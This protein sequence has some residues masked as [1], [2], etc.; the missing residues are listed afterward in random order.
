MAAVHHLDRLPAGRIGKAQPHVH[1]AHGVH[2]VVAEEGFGGAQPDKAHALFFRVLHLAQAA[3][4]VR[5]VAPVNT[6]YGRGT[7]ADGRAH[8][9]HRG[10]TTADHHHMLARRIQQ[11]AVEIGHV[12]AQALAVG[13][14]Q[15]IQ[16]RDDAGQAGA[17]AAD[18]ARLV[19]AGGQQ[20]RV[21]ARAQLRERHVT[22]HLGVQVEHDAA[23]LQQLPAAQH[24]VLFQL[25]AGD[26]VHHQAAHAV[27][28]VINMHLVAAAAQLLGR[29]KPARARAHHANALRELLAGGD[30][31]D[32]ALGERVVGDEAL[33]GTDGDALEAAL[34][35]AVAL[36]QPVLRADAAADLGEVVGGRAHL[37]GLVQ[38]AFRGQLQPVRNVVVQRAVDGTERHAALAAPAG[39]RL[40]QRDGEVAVDLV[41]I[42][43]ACR[44]IALV[45]LV[46][47]HRRELQHAVCHSQPP[48]TAAAAASEEALGK[49]VNRCE[50]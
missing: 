16:R 27:M 25:E 38:P 34:D 30:R 21:M 45:G 2:V 15:E 43:H 26:A 3:G 11:A 35:D 17:R 7:L 31:L 48:R 46:L 33:D 50:P 8:A 10:V 18:V 9:I 20:D 5:L 42:G 32:P 49:R 47:G 14:D 29:R 39:L 4:H 19:Y 13:G 40:R 37:V 22:A 12:V 28:P 6:A 44:R 1:R 36:A 24:D 41:K 23:L